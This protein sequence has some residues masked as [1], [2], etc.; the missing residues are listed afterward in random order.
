M[1]QCNGYE[2]TTLGTDA[3]WEEN[4]KTRVRVSSTRHKEM[5]EQLSPSWPHHVGTAVSSAV[6]KQACHLSHPVLS[7][8]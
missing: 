8:H 4:V 1:G 7:A 2:K 3:Q 6:R 5:H